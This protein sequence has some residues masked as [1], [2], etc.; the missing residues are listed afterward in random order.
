MD[1]PNAPPPGAMADGSFFSCWGRLKVKIA[2]ARVIPIRRSGSS[3]CSRSQHRPIFSHVSSGLDCKSV[4]SLA[5][6]QP[7]AVG[8]FKYDAMSYAQNFD[9]G[10]WD[11]DDMEGFRHGFSSRY[12]APYSSSSGTADR[13]LGG[14]ELNKG[15]YGG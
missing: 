8:G 7:K 3:S 4:S 10:L 12:A 14:E 2:W 13:K 6:I 9:E 5:V 15:N 1:N 11:D